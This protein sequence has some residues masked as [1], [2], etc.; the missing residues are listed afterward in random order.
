LVL[1]STL[2]L[3]VLSVL[4]ATFD[5]VIAA[6]KSRGEYDTGIRTIGAPLTLLEKRVLHT[7]KSSGEQ[8]LCWKPGLQ[9]PDYSVFAMTAIM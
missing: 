4:Q 3:Y 8:Q 5:A 6:A 1:L 7:D 9:Y 2:W